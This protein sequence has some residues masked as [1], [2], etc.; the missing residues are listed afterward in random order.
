MPYISVI[1]YVPN[2]KITYSCSFI[3]ISLYRLTLF[4]NVFAKPTQLLRSHEDYLDLQFTKR[5]KLPF[6][7]EFLF[8][9]FSDTERISWAAEN[10]S[11]IVTLIPVKFLLIGRILHSMSSK[12]YNPPIRFFQ[13]IC[14]LDSLF[15]N[16]T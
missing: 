5:N 1:I 4:L 6:N 15:L 8:F 2:L 10:K 9:L 3:F 16:L 12:T 7:S 14:L 11:F 13:N